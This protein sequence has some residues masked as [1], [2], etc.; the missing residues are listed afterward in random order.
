[1]LVPDAADGEVAKLPERAGGGRPEA[2]R[3]AAPDDGDGAYRAR[4]GVSP[5]QT[6]GT[7]EDRGFG[8][9]QRN[10]LRQDSHRRHAARKHGE[11]RY[12]K[13]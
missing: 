6:L 7:A 4:A 1:M 10:Q 9:T 11:E 13:F 3:A 8:P 5:G 12:S 2:V